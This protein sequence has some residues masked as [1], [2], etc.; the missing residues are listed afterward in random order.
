MELLLT[1]RQTLQSLA[2]AAVGGV[3]L[4]ALA[5]CGGGGGGDDHGGL[6]PIRTTMARVPVELPS[7]L[8]LALADLE[9]GTAFGL[10]TLNAT[11][12]TV[13][14]N[15]AAPTFAYLREKKTGK[16]VMAAL[17]G[18]G[19]PGVT[20]LGSAA[21]TMALAL[22]LTGLSGTNVAQAL[23]LLEANADV[24]AL[25]QTIAAALKTDP[26]ALSAETGSVA[27]AIKSTFDRLA[28]GGG[29]PKATSSR[30]RT[31]RGRVPAPQ[32]LVQ[33]SDEQSGFRVEQGDSGEIVPT[34]LR[35]R[36]AAAL[37]Y[38][39]GHDPG[40]G[41]TDQGAAVRVD[42][43]FLPSTTSLLGSLAS[44]GSNPAWSAVAGSPVSLTVEGQDKKTFYET[45]VLMAAPDTAAE[46]AFFSEA[47]YAGEVE[48]WRTER[49]KLNDYAFLFGISADL[50][51]SLGGALA[52]QASL[53]QAAT[54]AE[55]FLDE[56]VHGRP[57]MLAAR[58]GGFSTAAITLLRG[59]VS[60]SPQATQLTAVIL[61]LVGLGSVTGGE[62]AA[63]GAA[64]A[65]LA[66]VALSTIAVTGTLLAVT[67]VGVTYTDLTS[68]PTA[69][70]WQETALK[71][72]LAITPESKTIS[73]GASLAL[74]ADVVGRP[75]TSGVRYTWKIASGS[76]LATLSDGH[77]K[78]GRTF[79]TAQATVTLATT[80][81]TQGEL[82]VTVEAFVGDDILGPARATIGIGDSEPDSVP[83]TFRLIKTHRT[84]HP[85]WPVM[86]AAVSFPHKEGA[87]SVNI[88]SDG[89]GEF[90]KIL[91]SRIVAR[92]FQ[93]PDS[94]PDYPYPG[95][96]SDTYKDTVI[97]TYAD[98]D[99]YTE[100][101]FREDAANKWKY[102]VSY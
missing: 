37:T 75:A 23:A 12:L 49:K 26:Y 64:A 99:D 78:T 8:P 96:W 40:A 32:I 57:A 88:T 81:S 92:G 53:Q 76:E 11:G 80:P 56:A 20:P 2:F 74:T 7:G 93:T 14:V 82:V 19:R 59:M 43:Q 102:S 61:R 52:A 13:K 28:G 33:P 65:S 71:A 34:N 87:T 3:S 83:G 10:G 42:D 85:D 60:G 62:L 84:G 70:R 89:N 54:F 29:T 77:G 101:L 4:F 90:S 17:V 21:L 38:R 68:S 79:E 95:I 46:P 67:D 55:Q 100:N 16:V 41:S 15:A 86:I 73:A 58:G 9:G 94:T 35:R 51:K 6:G 45:V 36:P 66:A 31:S 91:G 63:A 48:T 25:G 50:F 1:R 69:V 97:L 44:L 22:G 27:T 72:D 39:V 98:S 30:A 18:S 47:R 5:G 24:K